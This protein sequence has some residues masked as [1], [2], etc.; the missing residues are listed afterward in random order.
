MNKPTVE[1]FTDGSC[2]GNPGIGGWATILRCNEHE[3]ILAGY[4]VE[5]TNNKMEL[6]AVIAGLKALKEPCK[7]KVVTDSQYV[8][9]GINKGWAESWKDHNWIKSDGKPALNKEYWEQLLKLSKEH[10]IEFIWVK[11]HNGHPENEHC[12]SIATKMAILAQTHS[13]KYGNDAWGIIY[14]N[15]VKFM[16]EETF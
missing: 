12:D 11:G 3:K 10:E 16:S 13:N 5:T 9:N 14:D 4:S 15:K 2:L 8:C 1:I 6:S 7:V